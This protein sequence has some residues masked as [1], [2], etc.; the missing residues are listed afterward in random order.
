VE[1]PSTPTDTEVTEAVLRWL[2][3]VGLDPAET[4]DRLVVTPTC[5]LAGASAGW[6]RTALALAATAARNLAG[7]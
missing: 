6:A 5:G 4:G 2:D 1:P 7:G 3:M